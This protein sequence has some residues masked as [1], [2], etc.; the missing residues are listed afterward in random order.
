[1]ET[2]YA[3]RY[4]D[5]Y[6]RHWWW[7][8]REHLIVSTLRSM[9]PAGGW[10]SILDVGCGDGLFFDRLTEFG[11]VEGVESE[12]SLVDPGGRWAS[13]IWIQ[14]FDETFQPR[15]QYGLITML[16]VV[17]H[18]PDAGA[19]LRR[20]ASLLE[21]AGTLLVTVPAFQALWTSHDDFNHHVQRFTR[22]T[23]ARA[24]EGAGLETIATRYFFFWTCPVKLLIR[25]KEGVLRGP[26][27][28]ARVPASFVN[29]ALYSLS[30]L[31]EAS[32]GRLPV[33]F[34]SSLLYVGRRV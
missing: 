21:P 22:K 24:I 15:K 13:R 18:L 14:P 23:L 10:P 8:A 34:G 16:D 11:G 3:H 12:A 30:R 17:E 29:R 19:A 28:M 2:E 26:S 5:L 9:A 7:R 25:L 33:P 27:E 32:L 1:M 20:A 6:L 31:E 4:R